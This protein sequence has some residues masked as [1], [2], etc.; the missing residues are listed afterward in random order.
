MHPTCTLPTRAL[1]CG[2]AHIPTWHAA[3]YLSRTV[4]SL[5]TIVLSSRTA[6]VW[7]RRNGGLIGI[8][9]HR[10]AVPN[11][12]RMGFALEGPDKVLGRRCCRRTY[13]RLL[14]GYRL[15]RL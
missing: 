13:F 4:Q 15:V 7:W 9:P 10:Q 8:E 6:M 14:D 1:H 11:V 2:D 3:A 12:E 5:S